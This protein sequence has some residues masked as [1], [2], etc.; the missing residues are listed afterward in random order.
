MQETQ[1][2]NL[3]FF[4]VGPPEKSLWFVVVQIKLGHKCSRK[5]FLN[6]VLCFGVF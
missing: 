4:R 3:K 5:C 1:S 2:L 6:A